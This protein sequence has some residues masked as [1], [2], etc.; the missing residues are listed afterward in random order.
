MIEEMYEKKVCDHLAA[1][2]LILFVIMLELALIVGLCIGAAE[3]F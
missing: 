3:L 2:K 1:I